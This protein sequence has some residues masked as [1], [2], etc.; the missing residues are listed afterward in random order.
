MNKKIEKF[1]QFKGKSICFTDQH[2]QYWIAIKPICQML[3][4]DYNRQF[5]MI[6]KDPILKENFW[7][8]SSIAADNKIRLMVCLPEFFIYVWIL[9]IR[10]SSPELL[11]YKKEC[12]RL[13]F[14]HFKGVTIP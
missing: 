11:E 8:Q 2:G 3:N 14:E 4:V 7:L 10:S 12:Y 13:I 1:L 9:A 5:I 6:K